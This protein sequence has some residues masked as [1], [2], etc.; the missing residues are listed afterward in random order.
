MYLNL[1]SIRIQ[2]LS[3]KNS[4]ETLLSLK[5]QRT[6]FINPTMYPN[7]DSLFFFINDFYAHIAFFWKKKYLDIK[8]DTFLC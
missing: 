1:K 4:K 5:Q 3:H 2:K 6:R 7:K 8:R